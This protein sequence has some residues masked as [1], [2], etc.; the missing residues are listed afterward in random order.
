[1]PK[2]Q[3]TVLRNAFV[4]LLHLT[5][6]SVPVSLTSYISWTYSL[7]PSKLFPTISLRKKYLTNTGSN[8]LWHSNIEILSSVQC[9][10]FWYYTYSI[11][12]FPAF[13]N[14][15]HVGELTYFHTGILVSITYKHSKSISIEFII[16]WFSESGARSPSKQPRRLSRAINTT[17]VRTKRNVTCSYKSIEMFCI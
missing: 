17:A 6:L 10:C 7:S 3:S 5:L 9:V 15:R 13:T 16:F 14:F 2:G 1:M 4:W 12:S 11:N 8:T